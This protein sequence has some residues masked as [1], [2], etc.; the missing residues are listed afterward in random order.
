MA[1][2]CLRP[3]DGEAMFENFRRTLKTS[4]EMW[5]FAGYWADVVVEYHKITGWNLEQVAKVSDG[6]TLLDDFCQRAM[7]RGMTA[8]DCAVAI[9]EQG[10]ANPDALD[11]S[12]SEDAVEEEDEDTLLIGPFDERNSRLAAVFHQFKDEV[13]GKEG[14]SVVQANHPQFREVIESDYKKYRDQFAGKGVTPE[15]NFT[16]IVNDCVNILRSSESKLTDRP[17]QR[18]AGITVALVVVLRVLFGSGPAYANAIRADADVTTLGILAKVLTEYRS[19]FADNSVTV[20]GEGATWAIAEFWGRCQAECGP[21]STHVTTA[22]EAQRYLAE[23]FAKHGLDFMGLHPVIHRA[24]LDEVLVFGR[25]ERTIEMFFETAALVQK[26]ALTDDEKA[27]MLLEVWKARGA[28][29]RQDD[30]T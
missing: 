24:L 13:E 7:R 20:F 9:C 16:A 28:T 14:Y 2:D 6:R 26:K 1:G 12:T 8:R 18:R 23:E 21:P 29:Y 25:V 22:Q 4:R 19:H 5:N 27:N 10:F 3:T 15:H 30:N 11:Q 17:D